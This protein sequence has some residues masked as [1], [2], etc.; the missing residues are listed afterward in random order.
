[1]ADADDGGRVRAP[2]VKSSISLS[3]L[4]GSSAEVASSSTMMSGSM[5]QNSRECQP[6]LLA[7]RQRLVPG[8]IFVDAVGEVAEPDMLQ[9]SGDLLD[10]L[11]SSGGVG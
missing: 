6:L 8:R 11:F 3:W 2:S 7:A 5:Q 1:M 9:A 4:S 10:R